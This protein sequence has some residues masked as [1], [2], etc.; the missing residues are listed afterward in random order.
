MFLL[1]KLQEFAMA[2][3]FLR[4]PGY[5]IQERAFVSYKSEVLRVLTEICQ[6]FLPSYL[7]NVPAVKNSVLRFSQELYK[8]TR[9]FIN[10]FIIF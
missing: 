5:L 6:T 2:D 7:I 4:L 9:L 10:T 3:L 8:Y 1:F